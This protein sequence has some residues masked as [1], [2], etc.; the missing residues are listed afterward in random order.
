MQTDVVDICAFLQMPNMLEY[1]HEKNLLELAD[2]RKRQR[3]TLK[4]EELS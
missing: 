3:A 1:G 2:T 4:S